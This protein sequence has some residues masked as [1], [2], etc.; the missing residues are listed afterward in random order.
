MLLK[1]ELIIVRESWKLDLIIVLKSW[2]TKQL[3]HC[4]PLMKYKM[5]KQCLPEIKKPYF[6][7][8]GNYVRDQIFTN[9][10]T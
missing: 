4:A 8:F 1:L 3:N 6:T 9:R 10:D 2:I 5:S 7:D